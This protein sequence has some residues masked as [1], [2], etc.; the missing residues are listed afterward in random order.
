MFF[1][2][3]RIV[4][5]APVLF[6]LLGCEEDV[7][8]VEGSDQAFSHYGAAL[9]T[10]LGSELPD[11]D[12]IADQGIE[13]LLI[14]V[15]TIIADDEWSPPGGLFNALELARPNVMTNVQNGYGFVGGGYR[16]HLSWQPELRFREAAGFVSLRE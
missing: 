13:Q 16:L 8:L 3:H 10:V 11:P 12:A 7:V 2:L 15:N 9:Y 14:T 5:G 4:V 6:A 1:S